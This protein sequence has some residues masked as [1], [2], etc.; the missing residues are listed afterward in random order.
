[1]QT[2]SS[3]KHSILPYSV[4][5]GL[6]ALLTTATQVFIQFQYDEKVNSHNDNLKIISLLT[7][8]V[9]LLALLAIGLIALSWAKYK[10]R[11][12][13]AIIEEQK[14][15]EREALNTQARKNEE[16]K[17][18]MVEVQAATEAKSF[19]LANMSHELRT[20]MNAVIGMSNLLLDTPLNAEQLDF[21]ETIRTSGDALLG[22]INDI[23]DFSKIES[24]KLDLEKQP[25]ELRSCIEEALDLVAGR[26]TEKGLELAYLIKDAT[27]NTIVGDI[28]RL[29]QIL[30]NLLS[31]AVKFTRKGEVTVEV[32]A[33]KSGDS[34]SEYELDFLV[35]D[36]GIG[37]PPE[38][39]GR[40]FQSFSQVDASTTRQYGG[41]GLG[42][43]ISRLLVEAL[44]G[45]IW[46]ESQAGIGTTFHFTIR[47]SAVPDKVKIYQTK[48]Q[49]ELLGK[50]VLI[51]DDNSTNRQILLIQLGKWGMIAQAVAS[52]RE[53]LALLTKG[54]SFNA[55]ILDMQMPEMDGLTLAKQIRTFETCRELPLVML[56]SLDQKLN[57]EQ[58]AQINFSAIL[59]KPIKIL[60][61]NQV[62]LN[63]LG[64]SRVIET[65][66][67]P[68]AINPQKPNHTHCLHILVAEDNPVN[69]KVALLMLEK[70]GYRADV[71]ANG[72]EVLD[73]LQRQK[74]D[75]VFLDVQMPEM[76]GLEAARRIGQ[77]WA[78]SNRPR[79]I[80]MT[81]NA[82]QGDR[83]KCL[84]AGMDDYIS[85]PVQLTDLTAMLNKWQSTPLEQEYQDA[86]LTE[87]SPIANLVPAELDQRQLGQ[88]KKISDGR[89]K[90]YAEELV[91]LYLTNGAKMVKELGKA[92]LQS[93]AD[94]LERLAHGF[95]GSSATYGA[96]RL[97]ELC[98]QVEYT[99]HQ[100][101]TSSG[102]RLY[103][104][105]EHEFAAVK[106]ALCKEVDL[107]LTDQELD[108][109]NLA[110][111]CPNS[112][113]AQG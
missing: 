56:T 48:N 110:G 28:T 83:E 62:L 18:A 65:K 51:V 95:R 53:A 59:R 72:L 7:S 101:D 23:L 42:L 112:P 14:E 32:D 30:V 91:I 9:S 35:K 57:K 17:A 15:R 99:A 39:M 36:T 67:P 38:K 5:F 31:N 22:V 105:I 49:P 13:S 58:L 19:F 12:V 79:L 25:F 3:T 80:A 4:A 37:I 103:P 78:G 61:L 90:N 93:D 69:Q 64:S 63:S 104:E 70:I 26:A 46:V 88:L 109:Q 98:R 34:S 94:A 77:Q 8:V 66:T 54:F 47:A 60:Q 43:V 21:V 27:P 81:A 11:Q 86:N 113:V 108:Y 89:G 10:I 85:K 74:Y 44:D 52:G 71:A 111:P 40:L 107:N 45:K 92:G 41:T 82:L 106:L 68:V 84:A 96:T 24:G 75:I 73:A 1:M 33:K 97:A 76:D 55:V 102:V 20:P 87:K 6:L 100:G 2:T 29:R 16:L 50:H